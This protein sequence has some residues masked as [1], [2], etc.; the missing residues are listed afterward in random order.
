VL[1]VYSDSSWSILAERPQYAANY[2]L[3]SGANSTAYNF[4]ISGIGHLAL[5]D[6]AL[7][8]PFLTCILDRQKSTREA[9]YFLKTINM[10]SLEFF[11]SYLKGEGEFTSSG[12]Y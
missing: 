8:S 4:Y 12:S 9:V 11:N 2:A 3:L 1:N 10:V 7:T 5:T 6:F